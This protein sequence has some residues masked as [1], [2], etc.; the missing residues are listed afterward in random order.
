MQFPDHRLKEAFLEFFSSFC[1]GVCG[2]KQF[3]FD[4]DGKGNT[5]R[6]GFSKCVLQASVAPENVLEM[7]IIRYSLDLLN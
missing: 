4:S 6:L 5:I 1:V 2:S 7:Q 3:S